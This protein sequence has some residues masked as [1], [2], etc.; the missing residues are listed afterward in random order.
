MK[1]LKPKCNISTK[2]LQTIEERKTAFVD[3][4][5]DKASKTTCEKVDKSYAEAVAVQP[6]NVISTSKA[7]S[8]EPPDLHQK[9]RK[10]IQIQ[11]IPED[12]DKSE[13]QTFV[14]T[15]NEVNDVLNRIGVTTQV[16]ELKR[17]VKF[18][19]TRKKPRTLLLTLPTEHDANLVLERYH[20]KR[21]VLTEKGVFILPALS[22][23]DAIKE[24]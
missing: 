11:G 6:R 23:E 9:T 8:K 24:N 21:T 10:N 5:V 19:N 12:P 22:K 13:A 15:T 14:T 18:S 4:R 17:L 20:E 16:T 7:H 3:T 1:R 2:K